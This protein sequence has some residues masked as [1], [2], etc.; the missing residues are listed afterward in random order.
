MVTR[1]KQLCSVINDEDINVLMKSFLYLMKEAPFDASIQDT[2]DKLRKFQNKIKKKK[3][4]AKKIKR[5]MT[6]LIS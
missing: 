2:Y 5:L 6:L 4:N 1:L 3:N